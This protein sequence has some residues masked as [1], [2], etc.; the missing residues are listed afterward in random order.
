MQRAYAKIRTEVKNPAKR[1]FL[2]EVKKTRFKYI[3][4]KRNE[5]NK[6]LTKMTRH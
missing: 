2:F 1:R 5:N 6:A 4:L 3:T